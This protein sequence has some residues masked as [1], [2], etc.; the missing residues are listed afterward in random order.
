MVERPVK[1]INSAS[2]RVRSSDEE[3]TTLPK[4]K[5]V[6]RRYSAIQ[7]Y[8]FTAVHSQQP[9]GDK[10]HSEH[11]TLPLAWRVI[12]IWESWNERHVGEA[13]NRLPATPANNG[14]ES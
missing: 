1:Q 11:W 12:K 3:W 9:S 4:K 10:E 2:G 6:K 5:K 8:Y 14:V 13:G 7:S